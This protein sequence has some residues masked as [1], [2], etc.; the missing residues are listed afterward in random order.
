[1]SYKNLHNE[2]FDENTICKLEIFEEYAKAWI[3]TF[4][5]QKHIKEIHIFDFFAGS[6]YDKEGVKGSPIRIIEK[7]SEQ[8]DNLCKSDISIKV[9]LNEY[10]PHKK[11]QSKFVQLRESCQ[12][13]FEGNNWIKRNVSIFYYNEDFETLFPKLFPVISESPALVYLDQN[14]IKYL[15]EKYFLE[16]AR[17]KQTDFLYFVSSS[18]FWRFGD[19]D[20]FKIHIDIDMDK[21][22]KNGYKLIHRTVTEH[23]KR[24]LPNNSPLKL[25]SFSIKKGSNIHGI[26]FGASHLR[27]VDKF[28]SIGWQR[29][30]INGEANFDINED[31]KKG[32]LNLFSSNQLTKIESFQENIKKL[33]LDSKLTDN[34]KLLEYTYS[35]GHI[36][37]HA[38]ECLRKLKKEKMV[39]YEGRSPCVTYDNVFN[40][41]KIVHYRAVKK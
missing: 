34:K 36:P 31:K 6:G 22:K 9:H 5:M 3:P 38:A 2:P 8:K 40:K 17:T 10:E 25:Y 33:V 35:Q 15:S 30:R 16:L 32:Q 7:I 28:L 11:K 24:S 14:G 27:A 21:A 26:I 29:N 41:K 37:S 20:E 19:K 12:S 39:D 1:M 23:L 13:F 18:Y 4:L